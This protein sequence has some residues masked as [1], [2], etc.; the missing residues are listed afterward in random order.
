MED[1][2]KE[3]EDLK[4]ACIEI[5]IDENKLSIDR[6]GLHI[7]CA[8][9]QL[10]VFDG[11]SYCFQTVGGSRYCWTE[12]FETTSKTA[13]FIFNNISEKTNTEINKEYRMIFDNI[14]NN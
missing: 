14:C 12:K 2:M 13:E 9:H 4:K 8:D 5:G 11:N 3:I 6:L 1:K 10:V 7:N